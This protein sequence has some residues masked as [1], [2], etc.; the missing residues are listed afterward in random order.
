MTTS[1]HGSLR[2]RL[3]LPLF[4][5]GVLF[6]F[7]TISYAVAPKPEVRTQYTGPVAKT[8]ATTLQQFN[9]PAAAYAGL[10]NPIVYFYIGG[11][12]YSPG[13]VTTGAGLQV[14]ALGMI[15]EP[16]P[17]T[18]AFWMRT[19]IDCSVA[20]QWYPDPAT[21][22][23]IHLG[24]TWNFR[25][26]PLLLPV[27]PPN[28]Q[29]PGS[30]PGYTF[31]KWR[32][33]LT[34]AGGV[35]AN[36]MAMFPGRSF[37][38]NGPGNLVLNGA[39]TPKTK[40]WY[41]QI[42]GGYLMTPEYL[43]K[44]PAKAIDHFGDYMIGNPFMY[45]VS[46]GDTWIEAPMDATYNLG[47]V[48]ATGT[49][50]YDQMLSISS[51]AVD[52]TLS[53]ASGTHID[54]SNQAGVLESGTDLHS[55]FCAEDFV[56][57]VSDNIR[58][59]FR[60]PENSTSSL[61][62]DYRAPGLDKYEWTVDLSTTMSS[63]AT[64]LSLDNF[65]AIPTWY[66]VTLTDTQ[67]G[68]VYPLTGNASFDVALTSG[69]PKT[70][71]LTATRKT[72]GVAEGPIAVKLN[73]VFPNPFNPATTI[74]FDVNKTGKVTLNVYN[75]SGQLVETLVNATMNAGSHQV[76]WN[77]KNHSSGV[78]IVRLISNGLTDTRKITFMK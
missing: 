31:I 50:L 8:T 63:I 57:P 27:G 18:R 1:L 5:L 44:L 41:F 60:N 22:V 32:N 29:L 20:F 58:L 42:P 12:S 45:Q 51:W 4:I 43:L 9:L 11:D 65:N 21:S 46:L 64:K 14:N 33:N 48:A 13:N 38:M 69:A 35:M 68:T 67:T 37:W 30:Y 78:Y 71:I 54:A 16:L 55:Y 2:R 47:K 25:S 7:T 75:V 17:V 56:A 28:M 40:D 66:S 77:A 72:T 26:I 61:A 59:A 73:N 36:D 15:V 24:D 53:D 76:V 70:F 39:P 23:S 3:Y 74:S 19:N 6:L 52:L 49:E 62:W 10:I 34:A